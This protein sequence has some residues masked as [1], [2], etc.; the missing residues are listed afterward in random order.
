[1]LSRRNLLAG[2][3]AAPAVVAVG[4]LMPLR[5]IKFDP[6]IRL[7]SWPIGED[8]QGLWW[9]HEGPL[10]QSYRIE[11]EM[12]DLMGACY[13]QTLYELPYNKGPTLIDS[14]GNSFL[15]AIDGVG[16]SIN[17]SRLGISPTREEREEHSRKAGTRYHFDDNGNYLSDEEWIAKCVKAYKET[18]VVTDRGHI[19]RKKLY[20]EEKDWVDSHEEAY[21]KHTNDLIARA[22]KNHKIGGL[23]SGNLGRAVP[24]H[25]R[26][27][28]VIRGQA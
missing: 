27:R 9:M 25:L 12:R 19:C 1:M 22:W 3:V 16:G 8:S 23:K 20:E 21:E 26:Q 28:E 13:S 18:F 5:G 11:T 15:G 24:S 14:R 2:L 7:Q 17:A 4:S 6:I 10:S